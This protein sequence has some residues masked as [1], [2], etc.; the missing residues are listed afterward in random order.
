[1]YKT[2]SIFWNKAIGY[3]GPSLSTFPSFE[4]LGVWVLFGASG[5]NGWPRWWFPAV[6][7]S[8]AA[9]ALQAASSSGS[10]RPLGWCWRCPG[11]SLQ[12]SQPW[13]W[14]QDA[15]LLFSLWMSGDN[16]WLWPGRAQI[17]TRR[18]GQQRTPGSQEPLRSA[19][20]GSSKND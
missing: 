20:S 12:S 9:G 3:R 1:M 7:V 10:P 15:G 19:A 13:W 2:A 8:R 18:A 4:F 5:C 16:C 14:C 6:T 11:Q 17:Y